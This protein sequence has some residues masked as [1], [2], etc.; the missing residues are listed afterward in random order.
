[1]KSLPLKRPRTLDI[2]EKMFGN[3][4]SKYFPGMMESSKHLRKI[5]RE[6]ESMETHPYTWYSC[7]RKIIISFTQK[8]KKSMVNLL[9]LIKYEVSL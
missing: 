6:G 4:K 5:I 9:W 3:E 2:S 1:M 7:F 8:S